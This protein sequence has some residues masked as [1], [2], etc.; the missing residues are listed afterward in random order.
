S[1]E[2]LEEMEGVI[3]SI[4]KRKSKYKKMKEAQKQTLDHPAEATKKRK[5]GKNLSVYAPS[6]KGGPLTGLKRKIKASKTPTYSGTG[7]GPAGGSAAGGGAP[8]EEAKEKSNE[9]N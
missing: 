5:G 6:G 2:S 3:R 7:Y 9:D 8:M 4:R 1:E